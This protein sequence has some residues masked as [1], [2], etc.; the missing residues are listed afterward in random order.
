MAVIAQRAKPYG[1][2]K[3]NQPID[4]SGLGPMEIVTNALRAGHGR[5]NLERYFQPG[6]I[7]LA[8]KD[9]AHEVGLPAR[10]K[11]ANPRF[12]IEE[13]VYD[14]LDRCS[15]GRY[16]LDLSRILQPDLVADYN[17]D[18]LPFDVYVTGLNFKRAAPLIQRHLRGRISV[19]P[20]H[21]GQR[22]PDDALL[23]ATEGKLRAHFERGGTVP[24]KTLIVPRHASRLVTVFKRAKDAMTIFMLEPDAVLD[25]RMG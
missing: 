21:V 18:P 16:N 3:S 8:F 10:R 12:D 11:N 15:Q 6:F 5:K 7:R 14:L 4:V 1:A 2:T 20:C 23:I 19:H 13:A 17:F 24:D 9:L 25:L 22:I